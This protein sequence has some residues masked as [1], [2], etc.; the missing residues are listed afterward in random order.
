MLKPLS[1][2]C[3]GRSRLCFVHV[4]ASIFS[5]SCF[6]SDRR[7]FA[8]RRLFVFVGG[9][10]CQACGRLRCW[11]RSKK[12]DGFSYGGR[13]SD[14]VSRHWT[15]LA[16]RKGSFEKQRFRS[17]TPKPCYLLEELYRKDSKLYI[18]EKS[19]KSEWIGCRWTIMHTDLF[20]IESF[21]NLLE[22]RG[23]G[24]H[25]LDSAWKTKRSRILKRWNASVRLNRILTSL[26][27]LLKLKYNTRCTACVFRYCSFHGD[28]II[29][30][31]DS[32]S[33][34]QIRKWVLG[35]W[36]AFWGTRDQNTDIT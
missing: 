24:V 31:R 20:Q 8:V 1:K 9:K 3:H 5:S 13:Q 26:P 19:W 18:T 6:T 22:A 34:C 11:V 16:V 35:L 7:R 36:P 27:H 12:C 30:K 2:L 29:R 25:K 4:R 15:H 32:Q 10:K 17:V 33:S 28:P 23:N 21:P 14:W